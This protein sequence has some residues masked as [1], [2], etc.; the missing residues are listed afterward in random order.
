MDQ[1]P[2]P[3]DDLHDICFYYNFSVSRGGCDVDERN[4]I[5]DGTIYDIFNIVYFVLEDNWRYFL[6]LV[7]VVISYHCLSCN[8]VFIS[9]SSMW[10][11]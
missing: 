9:H 3:A 11:S 10:F 7:V 5:Y 2:T 6:V 4:R 1:F 8:F